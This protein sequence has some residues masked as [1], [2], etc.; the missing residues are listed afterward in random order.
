MSQTALPDA[1]QATP[2]EPIPHWIGGERRIATQGRTAPVFDPALG[3]Q[4]REVPL[5]T[6]DELG[7]A[8][9]SR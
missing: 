4:I 3:R 1:A 8:V 9:A 5:A 2:I 6:A 7:E